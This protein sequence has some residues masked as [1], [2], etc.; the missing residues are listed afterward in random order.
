MGKDSSLRKKFFKSKS[1][2][3]SQHLCSNSDSN[4][5]FFPFTQQLHFI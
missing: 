3:A 2:F 5:Y 1:S 4:F